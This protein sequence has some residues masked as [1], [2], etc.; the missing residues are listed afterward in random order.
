VGGQEKFVRIGGP[1]P[2]REAA[3]GVGASRTSRQNGLAWL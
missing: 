3:L 2:I 1:H